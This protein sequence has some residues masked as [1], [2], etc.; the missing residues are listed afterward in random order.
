MSKK[1]SNDSISDDNI[2]VEYFKHT[3]DYSNKYGENTVVLMQVGS[4]LEVYGIRE[5]QTNEVS[6]S[7]IKDFAEICQFNIADKKSTFGN[8]G[9]IIMA[10]FM[11]YLLDKYLPRMLE[12]GYTVVIYLQEKDPKKD[13][14][15]NRVLYKIYS[16][17]TYLACDSDSSPQITNNIMC[18]WL[19]MSKPL[20]T[21]SL[22]K[23]KDVMVCGISVIN[24]FTGKSYIFEYQTPFLM[25]NTT[26][27]D[28]ERSVSVFNPSEILF[29]S[30][31]EQGDIKKVLQYSGINTT[32][33]HCYD[34]KDLANSK[35]VNCSNQQYIKQILTTFYNDETYD[36][37]SEFNENIMATQSFCFLLNFI[38]EHNPDLVRKISLPIFNNISDRLVLANHT[39]MQ[40]NII[41]SGSGN[42]MGKYSSVLSFLNS[43][44][45]S[46]GK[47]RFQYQLTNPTSDKDWLNK[48]YEM[49]SVM[50]EPEKYAMVENFRKVLTQ[51]RDIE[52]ICRQIVIKKIFPSSIAFLYKS[53]DIVQQINTCLY[54][55][56]NI[57]E[58]LCT[59]FSEESSKGY[60]SYVE[61]L[62]SEFMGYINKHFIIES[63]KKTNSMTN[64][65][66][67]IIREGVSKDL[68]AAIRDYEISKQIF[69]GLKNHLNQLIKKNTD[70]SGDV[71]FV[72]E[73][74]TEKSG[75]SLQITC[76][77]SQIL[78]EIID[79]MADPV[80]LICDTPI[81]IKDIKFSKINSTSSNMDI[82]SPFISQICKKMFI[83]KDIINKLIA[84]VYLQ[85]LVDMENKWLEKLENMV[86]YIAK[87][88]MLQCKTYL[89]KK[90]KYCR[91]EI[92]MG[93]PKSFVDA[94]E[95][96]HCLIEQIQ[97]NEI[98]VTNDISLGRPE[99]SGVLLYGTNAVGKTSLIRALGVSV[100]MA[101]AGMFVPCSRFV[102]K[103]YTAIYSRILGNDN[104]FKGLS[105]FAVEMSELRI[106]LK[107][108]DENSL[109]LGDELC[110][111][112]ESE[113]ALSI[114]AAGLM[115]LY[116]KDSSFI[117]ATHFHEIVNYSEI[118]E[119]ENIVL[120]HMSVSYDREN[121]CL[122]YDRKLR[123]G[124]GPRIYGL[125]VCK[126]LYLEDDFL[127]LAYSI[128]GKYFPEARGELSNSSTIYNTKKTRGTCEICKKN[129]G[130][131]IH[132]LSPQKDADDDGFIGT[133]HKN[134]KANL[135]SICEDCHDKIHR[136]KDKKIVKKKTT[137]G[138]KL[139]STVD[140]N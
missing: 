121:E 66:E 64:F 65:D 25:N 52:K 97:Q 96:R 135:V 1:V 81:N 102:Y 3:S 23:T 126:S 32:S 86:S 30:P 111:G 5:F 12:K 98:Y 29:I 120:K 67:N 95:L 42:N 15:Y 83:Y 85:V 93:S 60:A 109:I 6:G 47:R 114:F 130:E 62:C 88:D 76:K 7:K 19:H 11:V 87:V 37:C 104:I 2:Y 46:I 10:G 53:I 127:D 26:F 105:T 34:T 82:D 131:E 122:V 73:H 113:S 138:Y 61:N 78:R 116:E 44:C 22:S 133:F 90:H 125:E 24:I 14:T 103:P 45:S 56:P 112:T 89:A 54:E 69:Y 106:I 40:L 101:Q 20:L 139:I 28:L 100:I 75:V 38:Q 137:K 35:I 16:P 43:C 57:I 136:E 63:C 4:F 27:D 94:H 117:F 129:M 72:K 74:E 118:Q 110:S 70:A 92:D 50:L 58:Y 8:K 80:I 33:I 124:S 9:Q 140:D 91:P 39:L 55:S 134:H 18:V 48:E 119:R 17:G 51:V 77:R 115:K 59:D 68:D 21:S 108:A 107:M 13:K 49:V 71:D 84:E 99:Q 132:H 31:L 79:K 36:I 123:E 41:D 128:R